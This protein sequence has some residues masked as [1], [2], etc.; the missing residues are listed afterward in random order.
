MA[1]QLLPDAL[2]VAIGVLIYSIFSLSLGL[3]TAWLIWIHREGTSYV[4]LLAI[5]T[6]IGSLASISQQIHTIT[7]WRDIKLEQHHHTVANIGNP[8][9]AL[10]GGS[11]G[12]DQVL[13]YIQFACYG[14]EALL[15]FFW[16]AVLLQSV[17]QLRILVHSLRYSN[18]VAKASAVI[19]PV[20]A[21][22]L[23]QL[24]VLQDNTVGFFVI[25]NLCM[26]VGLV[27]GAVMLLSILGRYIYSRRALVSFRF[28]YGKS[29]ARSGTQSR[30]STAGGGQGRQRIYDR[31]LILR[32]AIGFAAL[33]IFQIVTI[34][35]EVLSQSKNDRSHLDDAADLSLAKAKSD[36]LFFLPG[37]TPPLVTFL[38]F[39]TTKPFR[40]YMWTHFV[41]RCFKGAEDQREARKAHGTDATQGSQSRDANVYGVDGNTVH[42][43]KGS[44]TSV[45]M[46]S[47]LSYG[48]REDDDVPI[49]EGSRPGDVSGRPH[50]NTSGSRAV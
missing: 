50:G 13:F 28:K 20:I 7:A 41:P 38:V 3:L 46:L 4:F 5:F 47:S 48:P 6:L 29:S 30:A 44:L 34:L 45:M 39:G 21:I 43:G 9:I 27:G 32:L 37:A 33:G 14:I 23:L 25:A 24:K 10:A 40:H 49:L 26:S 31:W 12:L 17:F 18:A 8:V 36:F 16:C 2:A 1:P 22:S 15:I 35:T 42:G 19:F 11:V